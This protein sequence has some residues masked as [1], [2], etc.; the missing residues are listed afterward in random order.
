MTKNS[1]KNVQNSPS[2]LLEGMS[3][4]TVSGFLKKPK[5]RELPY[6]PVIP[7]LGIYPEDSYDRRLP[8]LHNSKEMEA[9]QM[10]VNW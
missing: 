6:D 1:S 5:K 2:S 10:S 3:T 9:S 4:A 8:T 7:L